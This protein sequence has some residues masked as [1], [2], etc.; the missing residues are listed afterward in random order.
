MKGVYPG[1]ITN[2]GQ[3]IDWATMKST[4][5]LIIL[6]KGVCPNVRWVSMNGSS[7][8]EVNKK[9]DNFNERV[10]PSF[11]THRHQQTDQATM[12]IEDL[13]ILMNGVC[14]GVK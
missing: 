11:V 3:K 10:C 1:V 2:R 12:S 8:Y 4:K 13:I 7:S 9:T 6:M 5:D 14:P